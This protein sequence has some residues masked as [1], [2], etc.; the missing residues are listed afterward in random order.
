MKQQKRRTLAGAAE[1][2]LEIVDG[3]A[4]AVEAGKEIGHAAP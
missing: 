2:D 1:M 4:L 3:K